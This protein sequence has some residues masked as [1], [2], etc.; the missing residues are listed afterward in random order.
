LYE[1]K[2]LCG[3]AAMITYLV[4]STLVLLGFIWSVR[5][6]RKNLTLLR[7]CGTVFFFWPVLLAV[8]CYLL[9]RFT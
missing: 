7:D 8:G 1:A 3:E 5:K 6:D 4:L 9:W 2:L